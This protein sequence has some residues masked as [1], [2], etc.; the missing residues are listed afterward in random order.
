M[1]WSGVFF[2]WRKGIHSVKK[3]NLNHAYSRTTQTEVTLYGDILYK[4]SSN[5]T[6]ITH[7]HLKTPFNRTLHRRTLLTQPIAPVPP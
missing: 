7:P 6:N 1:E 2:F 5:Y 3:N 4:V